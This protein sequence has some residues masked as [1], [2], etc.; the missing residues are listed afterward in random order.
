MTPDRGSV[1][2]HDVWAYGYVFTPPIARQRMGPVEALL[3]DGRAK[4]RL[5]AHT[6]EGRLINGDDVTHILVISDRPD[7]DL[8]VNELLEAE[9][10]RLGAPF[11]ITEA[12]QVGGD[13]GP[14]VPPEP[15]GNA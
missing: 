10:D 1:P 8:E 14:G 3:N 9:L 4:A 12:V 5:A 2:H 13:S 11:A 7:Q 15:M 6:W